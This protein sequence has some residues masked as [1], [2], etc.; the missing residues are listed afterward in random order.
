MELGIIGL[1]KSGKTTV[2]NA[3]TK[4]WA[5]TGAYSPSAEPNI[6]VVKVPDPRLEALA[7]MFK[8]KRTVPADVRYVDVG[9]PPKGFGK[10]EGLGGQYLAHLSQVDA[11]IHVVRAFEDEK[12]PHIQGS[13]DPDRD[14]STMG[15][16]LAFS[17]LALFAIFF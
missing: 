13:I 15:L 1:P 12:V 10:G 11:L 16:E 14:M 6:G 3:L 5:E 9:A 17:D 7:N 4:S 2:F 8:P